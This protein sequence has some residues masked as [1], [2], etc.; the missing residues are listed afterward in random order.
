MTARRLIRSASTPATSRNSAKGRTS[1]ERTQPT[2]EVDPPR[3]RIAKE[4]ATGIIPV[5]MSDVARPMK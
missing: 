2:S 4:R 1:A 5:P 3:P